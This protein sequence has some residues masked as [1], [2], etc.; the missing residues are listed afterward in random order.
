MFFLFFSLTYLFFA[1]DLSFGALGAPKAGFL[2]TLAG[3][4]GTLLSFFAVMQEVLRDKPKR[5]ADFYWSKFLFTVIGLLF[6]VIV[7]NSI[8]YLVATFIVMLYWLKVTDTGGWA[9]P[10]F[11]AAG[12]ALAF[13]VLF[14][15]LGVYL[16]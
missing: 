1:R 9:T 10:F 12:V 16:P 4:I 15:Q 2:P 5:P 8:G 3:I 11:V 6:Y 13:S 7:L 14:K